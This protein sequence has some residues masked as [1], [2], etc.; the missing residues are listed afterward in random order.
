MNFNIALKDVATSIFNDICYK[1]AP[2]RIRGLE[3]DGVFGVMR[4][5]CP[6]AAINVSGDT[7]DT[8]ARRGFKRLSKCRHRTR[9]HATRFATE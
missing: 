4:S 2:R 6:Q 7:C 8:F 1:F 3:C 9:C 5:V